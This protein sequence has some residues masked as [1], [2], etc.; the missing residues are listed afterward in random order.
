MKTLLF[1]HRFQKVGWVIFTLALALDVTLLFEGFDLDLFEGFYSGYIFNNIAIIGTVIGAIL[2]T[3]SE[4]KR[5]D[6]MIAHI[7]LNSLLTALYINYALLIVAA[8][9]VYNLDFLQVMIYHMFTILI[10]FMVVFRYQ[11]WRTQKGEDDEE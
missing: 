10:V 2:V 8:L 1:P 11:V 6:E 4:E 7:R 3:C 9:V 5:E